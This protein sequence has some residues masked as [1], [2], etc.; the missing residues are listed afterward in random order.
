MPV[1][2]GIA[3]TFS[4]PRDISHVAILIRSAGENAQTMGRSFSG[5]RVELLVAVMIVPE[6]D[7]GASA[8][9]RVRRIV[10]CHIG[11]S[12]QDRLRLPPCCMVGAFHSASKA[13]FGKSRLVV[14]RQR[15]CD[16]DVVAAT[17]VM[18]EELSPIT[19]HKRLAFCGPK[20][21]ISTA[22]VIPGEF[23]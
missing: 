10:I 9:P 2:A 15:R 22:G 20:A 11:E 5:N 12:L 21:K 1:Q 19:G 18:G 23:A 3:E 13:A 17:P 8:R 7:N 4:P 14:L 16:A 6:L